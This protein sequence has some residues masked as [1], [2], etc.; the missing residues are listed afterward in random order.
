M[1]QRRPLRSALQRAWQLRV[2]SSRGEHKSRWIFVLA[3][4]AM[5][6]AREVW[7]LPRNVVCGH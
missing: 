4:A 6:G 3:L 2:S 7:E 1:S 5:L